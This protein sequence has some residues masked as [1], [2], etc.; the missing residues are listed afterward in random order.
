MQFDSWQA[1]WAMGG[2]GFYVWL[3][4]AVSLLALIVLIG[5]SL[6][7]RRNLVRLIGREQQRLA[8]IKRSQARRQTA[9]QFEVDDE[10]Q[11]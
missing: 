9:D 2:Y 7:S 3:A 4:F 10:P 8:R 6:I 5:H 1:F 11:T